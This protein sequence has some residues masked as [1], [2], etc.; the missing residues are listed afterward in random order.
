MSTDLCK[1]MHYQRCPAAQRP[2]QAEGRP[3][4][5]SLV[6][7]TWAF[8]ASPL[9]HRPAADGDHPYLEHIVIWCALRIASTKL[10]NQAILIL[11]WQ[12]PGAHTA[13]APLQHADDDLDPERTTIWFAGK[14]LVASKKLSDYLGRHEKTK[15]V[16]KLTRAGQGAPAREQVN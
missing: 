6:V 3:E 9:K 10:I 1:E 11:K 5:P 14:A 12:S 13:M 4:D 16:V 7:H 8:S 2:V 15:A